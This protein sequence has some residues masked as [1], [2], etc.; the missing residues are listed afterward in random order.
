ML[1]DF[2]SGAFQRGNSHRAQPYQHSKA[3]PAS[4]SGRLTRRRTG[5][6]EAVQC[7]DV[8]AFFQLR[9]PPLRDGASSLLRLLLSPRWRGPASRRPRCL[10]RVLTAS[11]VLRLLYT[12]SS[13]EACTQ[14][15]R[16]QHR[17]ASKSLPRASPPAMEA[18]PED[19]KC[20]LIT[21]PWSAPGPEPGIRQHRC[22]PE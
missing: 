18:V 7:G 22:A 15:L 8:R 20:V 2:F 17:H 19:R 6:P 21:F 14:P 12:H 9:P 4:V 16:S 5:W 11:S 13:R 10:S 3:L 1:T